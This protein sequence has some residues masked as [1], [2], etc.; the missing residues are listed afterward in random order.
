MMKVSMSESGLPPSALLLS[1]AK[2][3]RQ[4]PADTPDLYADSKP[5]ANGASGPVAAAYTGPSRL[6]LNEAD[7]LT[8]I[9]KIIDMEFGIAVTDQGARTYPQLVTIGGG[10]RNSTLNVLRVGNVALL[11]TSYNTQKIWKMRGH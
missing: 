3:H 7:R 8:G 6:Q 1:H 10:S 5:V 11:D 9:G 2:Y 4:C